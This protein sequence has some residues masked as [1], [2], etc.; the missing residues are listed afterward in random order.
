[1]EDLRRSIE[2]RAGSLPKGLQRH[3][4]RVDAIA[5][6]L[7]PRHGVAEERASLGMMAH[8]VARAMGD[9]ELLARAAQ[10][11][12]AVGSAELA[13]PLLLHGP[14]GAELLVRENGLD[15]SSLHQAVYWHTTAHPSLD[16]LGK[17]V[18]VSDKLDPEKAAAYPYQARVRELAWEDLDRAI[19]EFLTRQSAALISRGLIAHPAAIETRDH[20]SGRLGPAE[21]ATQDAPAAPE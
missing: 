4:L 14:V 16:A 17:V 3:I 10:L 13:K 8:D 19:L 18:F 15:D 5:R 12:L 11:G 7:G 20:L 1:M 2:R 21:V 9:R 6:E